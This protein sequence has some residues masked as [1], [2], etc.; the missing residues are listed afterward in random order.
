MDFY[1][2]TCFARNTPFDPRTPSGSLSGFVS[3]EVSSST[4]GVLDFAKID[5]AFA[6]VGEDSSGRDFLITE[7]AAIVLAVRH[8]AAGGNSPRFVR[9]PEVSALRSDD[10]WA[11]YSPNHD[12]LMTADLAMSYASQQF[13]AGVGYRAYYASVG[14]LLPKDYSANALFSGLLLSPPAIPLF[15]KAH[16][17][18]KE[19]PE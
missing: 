7:F 16:L 14:G 3:N 11:V 6:A 9:M 1:Q 18:T 13:T 2:M 15:W 4:P 12:L 10:G 19:Q 8:Y 5:A 17:G